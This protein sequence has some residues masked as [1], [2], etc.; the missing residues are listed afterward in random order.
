MTS[1]Y[2]NTDL[3]RYIF[4]NELSQHISNDINEGFISWI[5]RL[6]K[7][8]WNWL[9]KED[10][11][12]DD[13]KWNIIDKKKCK[14]TGFIDKSNNDIRK[15]KGLSKQFT[16][17]CTVLNEYEDCII[18]NSI[19]SN[20]IPIVY[21]TATTN[22]KQIHKLLKSSAKNYNK[23][24]NYIDRVKN[25][26][27]ILNIEIAHSCEDSDY[28]VYDH[29]IIPTITNDMSRK[30]DIIF[31]Y[32]R[33]LKKVLREF[34]DDIDLYD[35]FP[36]MDGIESWN[37]IIDADYNADDDDDNIPDPDDG[38]LTID[39]ESDDVSDDI[40]YDTIEFIDRSNGEVVATAKFTSDKDAIQSIIGLKINTSEYY[41]F[42]ITRLDIDKKYDESEYMNVLEDFIIPVITD[43]FAKRIEDIDDTKEIK[44][45]IKLDDDEFSN[46]K[47]ALSKLTGTRKYRLKE[48]INNMH[49]ILGTT[50]KD[51]KNNDERSD[52][53]I[54][55][56]E[57][58]DVDNIFWMLETWF[59]NNE[60]ERNMFMSMIDNC[61]IKRTYNKNDLE[62]LCKNVHLDII[63]FINFM[64]RDAVLR[65]SDDTELDYYYELKKIIDTIIS[66]KSN[67]N[68]WVR[69]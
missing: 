42:L 65:S 34:G 7:K 11:T 12:S 2:N 50:R 10:F 3:D 60:Q 67:S 8:F 40:I 52:K 26:I 19:N 6:G 51:I 63:P 33:F 44:I 55:T 43:E 20:K 21:Y 64:Y 56:N 59:G 28:Y 14:Y 24:K 30:Y 47:M 15:N 5:A 13:I 62:E 22:K 46:H 31:F 35:N 54:T 45:Y 49:I 66:N 58:L 61:I 25:P 38:E 29:I 27:M 69:I 9:N 1:N 41:N 4:E 32:N 37:N 39:D 17:T 36:V 57:S 48:S 23:Y 18:S 53:N 68:K 16:H